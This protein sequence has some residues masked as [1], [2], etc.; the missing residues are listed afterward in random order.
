MA[1]GGARSPRLRSLGALSAA[2]SAGLL[3]AGVATSS[4][5]GCTTT[6]ANGAGGAA[7][8]PIAACDAPLI[9]PSEGRC[10]TFTGTGGGGTGSTAS[11]STTTTPTGST[12]SGSTTTTTGRN[13]CAEVL[14]TSAC[15]TCLEANC[16]TALA[17]CAATPHCLEYFLGSTPDL[18]LYNR[19]AVK[20][21]ADALLSCTNQKCMPACGPKLCNPVT[22][23]GCDS[24]A[25]DGP[26]SCDTPEDLP[27]LIPAVSNATGAKFVCW[28]APNDQ[29]QCG[30]CDNRVGPYCEP[31]L[32][33][34]PD[35]SCA[36]YCCDDG[37]C[38]LDGLCDKAL[39]A[40][41]FGGAN[42]GVCVKATGR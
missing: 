39:M 38:G 8:E 14:G 40:S 25:I 29:W 10:F 26:E 30:G 2:V 31:G 17:D 5:T 9:A 20:P 11:G 15:E 37:D 33:C 13:K 23:E 4:F 7:A 35:H 27:G 41:E 34:L 22:N 42:V 21:R 12:T 3:L 18:A 16:C 36:K 1:R 19:L 24:E 32:A 28:P 6:C